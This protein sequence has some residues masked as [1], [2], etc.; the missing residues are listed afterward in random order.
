MQVHAEMIIAPSLAAARVPEAY[1]APSLDVEHVACGQFAID[2]ARALARRAAGKAV[3]GEERT[4]VIACSA[5]TIEAQNA[6]LKLFEDP[7]ARARFILIV[8]SE[9]VV[10]ETLRSRFVEVR[11]EGEADTG[12]AA[13]FLRS[14]YAERLAAIAALHTRKDT[15]GMEALARD[16][17]RELVSQGVRDALPVAAF[18]ESRIRIKGGSRKML[19]EHLALSLPTS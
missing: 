5:M 13:S 12:D 1:A 8:P 10:I 16:V 9:S 18:V 3:A 19:L 6:L 7:P 15:N 2:D 4:F 17:A 11:R 14:S